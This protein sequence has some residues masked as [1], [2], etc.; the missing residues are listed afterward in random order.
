MRRKIQEI[1]SHVGRENRVLGKEPLILE[2]GKM[3]GLGVSH[4][5]L[6]LVI[7]GNKQTK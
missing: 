2:R 6:S 4:C 5:S 3:S 7:T 1:L